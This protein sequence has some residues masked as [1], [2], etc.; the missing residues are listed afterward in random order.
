MHW[1]RN[2]ARKHGKKYLLF[3]L[4]LIIA[5]IVLPTGTPEDIVTTLVFIK[6]FGIATYAI[7]CLITLILVLLL[8]PKPWRKK[9]FL[10]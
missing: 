2:H 9:V 5:W 10:S 7:M 4:V 8:L 3:T 1:L 6:L